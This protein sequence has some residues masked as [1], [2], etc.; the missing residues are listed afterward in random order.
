MRTY[1][2]SFDKLQEKYQQDL[3]KWKP[4]A[5]AAKKDGKTPPPQPRQPATPGKVGQNEPGYLYK[6][7]H[8]PAVPFAIRGVLWDQGESGTQI[9]GVDQY[10][11]MAR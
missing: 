2:A 7:Q 10:T 9:G 11:L 6:A 5:E 1:A 4:L 8:Q 3:D